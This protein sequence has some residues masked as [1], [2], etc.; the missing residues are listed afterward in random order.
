ME[1]TRKNLVLKLNNTEISDFS[2]EHNPYRCSLKDVAEMILQEYFDATSLRL[3]IKEFQ[4]EQEYGYRETHITMN[5]VSLLLLAKMGYEYHENL[6]LDIKKTTTIAKIKDAIETIVVAIEG[7][8]K[9]AQE[10]DFDS[11]IEVKINKI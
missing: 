10:L 7:A 3:E 6:F 4:Q 9:K 5:G 2:Y 1:I 8:I 11:V